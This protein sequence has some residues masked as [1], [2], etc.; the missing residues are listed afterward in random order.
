MVKVA[1]LVEEDVEPITSIVPRPRQSI[2]VQH[3]KDVQ[4]VDENV[5]IVHRFR[6]AVR[7]AYFESG[8]LESNVAVGWRKILHSKRFSWV[9]MACL[10]AALFFTELWECLQ[11]PGNVE[12][13]TILTI[14]MLIFLF[15]FLGLS[16]TD[17]SYFLGF[18]FWMDLVGTASMLADVSYVAGQDATQSASASSSGEQNTVVVR[19][20]RAAK[21][22]ARAGR[23]SR[24]LKLLRFVMSRDESDVAT[25]KMAKVISN[26]LSNV[27]STRVAFLTIATVVVMPVFNLFTYPEDDDSMASWS[28][29]LDRNVLDYDAAVAGGDD[30]L[31]TMLWTRIEDEVQAFGDFY[32]DGGINYGPFRACTGR[33]ISD[34]LFQCERDIPFAG[35]YKRPRR[36]ASIVN[37]F[38]ERLQVSFTAETPKQ[39][40]AAA[41]MILI[42][43][44]IGVMTCFG[45]I[46]SSS[47]S[48]IAL[49]PL[50]R[51]LTVVRERC[52][53]IFKYTDDLKEEESKDGDNSEAEEYDDMEQSSEFALLE[54]VVG[55]LAAIAQ[56]TTENKELEVKENMDED[57]LMKLNW[58]QGNQVKLQGAD[59]QPETTPRHHGGATEP[60]FTTRHEDMDGPQ[61]RDLIPQEALETL[62]GASFDALKLS[63]EE[64]LATANYIIVSSDGCTVWARQNVEDSKLI[65]FMTILESKYLAN[66]FHNFG[67]AVDVVYTVHRFFR[68][69]EAHIY[70]SELS[71]FW[72]LVA[73]VAHDVGH[74]GV[75]NQY[76]IETSHE[77]ALKYNDRSPLENMHC[78]TFFHIISDPDANIFCQLSKDTYKE[79]RKGMIGS[80]L[81][82]DITLHNEMIKDLGML[83]QMNQEAFD[84]LEP[85]SVITSSQNNIQ[86]IMNAVLHCADVAN[87][88]KPWPLCQ[89]Y[90]FACLD[91]FFAQGDIEKAK[92][93]PVQMLNDREKVNRPN[94]QIGF[95]EFLICPYVE[96]FVNCFPQV[97]GLA[98]NLGE[99]IQRWSEV[100][101]EEVSPPAEAV[102]K[103]TARVQK[104]QAR[105]K[106]VTMQ[107][108]FV[109]AAG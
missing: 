71:Q 42:V 41:S 93:I 51:M 97:D 30:A 8:W 70:L 1:P 33:K 9:T 22:G 23:L 61:F 7:H 58:M 67:H 38:T 84:N 54:K 60:A 27:L 39:E 36:A 31:A 4:L 34:E 75:N 102:A 37:F 35:V 52:A 74:I 98:T 77:L 101:Q 91:E 44:I 16:L 64:K 28:A 78:S 88:M 83:F 20:A 68:L 99:N 15:E 5:M 47:I 108:R 40:E 19:A 49:Q 69:M 90:A 29:L 25:V 107:E 3:P 95:I 85:G 81:H 53:Q 50:E 6:R 21:L 65:K 26:Q 72:L 63:R 87:P 46:M 92:G 94:S 104:V 79:T 103:V 45:L 57:D 100:W 12:L 32:K 76:L 18:F 66:P 2:V 73:A 109:F 62:E 80:I 10:F 14:V 48:V 105:C 43:F 106:A 96:A 89:T 59:K 82:T 24:V 13:D 56:L 17:P 11:V 86:L 55:K